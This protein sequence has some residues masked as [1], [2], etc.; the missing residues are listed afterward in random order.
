MGLDNF[1]LIPKQTEENLAVFSKAPQTQESPENVDFENVYYHGK[2][3][4][5][6]VGGLF[7]SDGNG[8]FR[9]K[10]YLSM[11]DAMLKENSWLYNFHFKSEIEDAYSQMSTYLD[12][13]LSE[14]AEQHWEEFIKAGKQTVVDHYGFFDEYTMDEAIDFIRM[15]EYYS[16]VENICLSAWY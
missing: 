6:L 9:G 1:W 10:Y 13:F 15:F 11:C 12:K 16:T 2:H 5:S 14:D 3:P 4:I 8:S 7:T